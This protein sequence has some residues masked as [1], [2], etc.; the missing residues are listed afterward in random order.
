MPLTEC[1]MAT[2]HH[3]HDDTGP[4]ES[5]M[6]KSLSESGIQSLYMGGDQSRSLTCPV[7]LCGSLTVLTVLGAHYSMS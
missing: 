3:G 6:S 1:L 4:L 2:L 5:G 7:G